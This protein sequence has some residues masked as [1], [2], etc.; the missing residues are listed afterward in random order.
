MP[1]KDFLPRILPPSHRGPNGTA[2]WESIGQELD[3][4]RQRALEAALVRF[5]GKA[6]VDALDEIGAERRIERGPGESDNA[7]AERLRT[8]W[9][10]WETAGSHVG[11][12]NALRHSGYTGAYIV[13]WNGLYATLDGS[14]TLVL[15]TLGTCYSRDPDH[16]GWMFDAADVHWAKF[17][18]VVP[19]PVVAWTA[20]TAQ[21]A[22][23]A[24]V[25]KWKPGKALF[26]GTALIATGSK[27]LGWPLQTLG[28]AGNLGGNVVTFLNPDGVVQSLSRLAVAATLEA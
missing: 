5:P 20:S 23:N 18:L 27:A 7:Y 17:M 4:Q 26:E 11:L 15:G 9:E 13:Q 21:A 6:P 3:T 14:N 16:A 22:V 1:Y 10:A 8:A 12:L 24:I 2:F 19:S 28:S 25:R